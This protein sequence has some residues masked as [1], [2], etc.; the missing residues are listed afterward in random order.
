MKKFF[1]E[2]QKGGGAG[3]GAGE[4]A[5]QMEKLFEELGKSLCIFLESFNGLLILLKAMDWM[6]ESER[7]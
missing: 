4:G 3:A 6:V 7:E 5:D 1:E 2:L